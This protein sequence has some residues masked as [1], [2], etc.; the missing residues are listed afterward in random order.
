[1]PFGD[2]LGACLKTIDSDARLTW[3]TAD[4]LAEHDLE[5]WR[6]IP[7]WADSDSAL[8]GS[9]TW[10]AD[11]ALAAGLRISPVED[12]VRDTLAWFRSLPQDRQQGLRA[13]MSAEKEASVLA[14][15]H[16]FRKAAG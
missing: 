10:S 1:M 12:T 9:L 2:L 14:A 7:A 15:W 8:A 4:F 3:V 16:E 11:K 6:D 5:A 13:G